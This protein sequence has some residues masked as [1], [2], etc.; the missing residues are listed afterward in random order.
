MTWFGY[1]GYRSAAVATTGREDSSDVRRRVLEIVEVWRDERLEYRT[2][3]AS[4]CEN[5]VSIVP[6]EIGKTLTLLAHPKR[7][8]SFL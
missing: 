4:L 2:D 6:I 8:S 3:R 5:N 1:H 7:R